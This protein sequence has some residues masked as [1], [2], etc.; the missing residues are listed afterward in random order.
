MGWRASALYRYVEGRDDLLEAMTRRALSRVHVPAADPSEWRTQIAAL[1]TECLGAL[2]AHPGMAGLILAQPPADAK[3]VAIALATLECLRHGGASETQTQTLAE[4]LFLF[5][6][7]T[8]AAATAYE[9]DGRSGD[10]IDDFR[11]GL[12]SHVRL[13]GSRQE[14]FAAGLEV[15]MDAAAMRPVGAG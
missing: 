1:S 3:A 7:A 2:D 5:V 14:R 15:I 13:D 4:L 11:Q 9:A 8:S 6:T 12:G 10:R